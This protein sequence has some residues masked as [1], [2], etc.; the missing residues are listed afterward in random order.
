M[1]FAIVP[2][3]N[4]EERVGSVVRN[5]L[6]FVDMVIVVDDGS[7]DN[8][9]VVAGDAGAQVIRHVINRGQGAALETGHTYARMHHAQYVLH[10]DAD[11]Q[12]SVDDIGPALQALKD[13]NADV[14][15]G[16]RYGEKASNVPFTKRYI[17]GP[18]GR[19]VDRVFGSVRLSDAHNGFRIL[20]KKALAY[21]HITQS[22][23]AHASEIPA[24]VKK[25][26][27][28]YIEVPVSVTY[29]EY[30]QGVS[31]GIRTVRD[32]FFGLFSK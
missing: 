4:E 20:T 8:T 22:G 30:G 1:F 28:S 23:M 26:H 10:F 7:T 13:A 25:H 11:G 9:A 16:T 14:L 27:L 18:I 31:S 32:L 6:V 12:F 3:Y 21:I 15:F 29:H 24:L 2:A 17:L 5:L 19:I